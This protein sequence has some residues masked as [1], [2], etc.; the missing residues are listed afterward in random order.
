[1][2]GHRVVGVPVFR[3]R[4]EHALERR[5]PV[6][7]VRVGM[8]VAL[9]LPQGDQLG[10]LA[11]ERRLD[12]A[13]IL[14]Q[15]R[16]D[17]RQSQARVDLL[18]GL[19]REQSARLRAEQPVLVQLEPRAD[20]H[21]PDPD[22]VRLRPGEVDHRGA[23]GRQ[24]DHPEVDLEP[25]TG[26]DR[27]LRVAVGEHAIGH[28]VGR[29]R[30]HHRLRSIG[31]HEQIDVAD[32]LG[33]AAQ[34]PRIGGSSHPGDVEQAPEQVLRDLEGLVDQDPAPRRAQ[35]LRPGEHV[36]LG[37]A[38]EP[39]Q[40]RELAAFGGGH[41]LVD[42]SDAELLV[43]RPSPSSDRTPGSPSSRGRRRAPGPASDSSS[44]NVPVRRNVGDLRR[45]STSRRRGSPARLARRASARSSGYPPTAR[46]AFS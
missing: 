23:P 42:R 15:G 35:P 1:M 30:L 5:E 31:S 25:M 6:G 11:G 45:R 29:E 33:H 37:R 34:R 14:T 21:L 2:V 16:L 44:S 28:D 32:R 12:L 27:G 36:A 8:Q 43:A 4:L 24:R 20:R 9:D 7:E 41:E 18:L 19:G 26:H 39:L 17:E 22:V 38:G 46:A 13:S 40:R 10:K 3:G